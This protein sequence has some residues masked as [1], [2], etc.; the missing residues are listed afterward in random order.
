MRIDWGLRKDQGNS[1][2]VLWYEIRLTPEEESLNPQVEPV[3]TE[4]PV[5][6]AIFVNGGRAEEPLCEMLR[7]THLDRRDDLPRLLVYGDR[8]RRWVV[9]PFRPDGAAFLPVVRKAVD[10]LR[11]ALEQALM[12]AVSDDG[13]EVA[14]SLEMSDEAKARLAAYIARKKIF[15]F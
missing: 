13:F 12:K 8:G 7:P 9:L 2:P 14:G 10:A 6:L 1:R 15:P 5:P 4:V 11:L 3:Q